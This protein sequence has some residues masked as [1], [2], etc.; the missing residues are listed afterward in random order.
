MRKLLGCLGLTRALEQ[1]GCDANHPLLPN[2]DCHSHNAIQWVDRPVFVLQLRV[3]MLML[4]T[5][6]LNNLLHHS[7]C[8]TVFLPHPPPLPSFRFT[9]PAVRSF[10]TVLSKAITAQ[11]ARAWQSNQQFFCHMETALSVCAQKFGMLI[12][13]V[14]FVCSYSHDT[15]SCRFTLHD[16]PPHLTPPHLTSF[17]PILTPLLSTLTPPNP[18]LQAR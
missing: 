8:I 15:A 12:F 11:P 2:H 6:L 1:V 9:G 16:L 5:H 13:F 3:T 14:A 17:L 7:K 10:L 4:H 18:F